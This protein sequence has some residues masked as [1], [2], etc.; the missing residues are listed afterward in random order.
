MTLLEMAGVAIPKNIR[1][2]SLMPLLKREPT[3]MPVQSN[4]IPLCSVES[5]V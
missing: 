1:G 5:G 3:D 2:R 4:A